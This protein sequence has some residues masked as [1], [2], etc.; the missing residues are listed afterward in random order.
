M[1]SRYHVSLVPP[2]AGEWIYVKPNVG[3]LL[4]GSNIVYTGVYRVAQKPVSFLFIHLFIYY[5]A[6]WQPCTYKTV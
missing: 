6:T 5:Y 3:L 2:R 4:A 1:F